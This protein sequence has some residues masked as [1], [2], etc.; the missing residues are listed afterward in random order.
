M[1]ARAPIIFSLLML[2]FFVS[3]SAGFAD[4]SGVQEQL[5][6]IQLKLIREKLKILQ[7]NILEAGKQQIQE[8]EA[9]KQRALPTALTKIEPNGEELA[10][11]LK[12]QVKT[13]Q[14]V[15]ATLRPRA[16]EEETARIEKRIGQIKEGL[17]T[18]AGLKLRS[19]QDEL[20]VLL[21]EYEA[22]QEQVRQSLSESI[23]YRQALVIGEQI[24]TIQAKVQ[25]LPREIVKPIA[26]AEAAPPPA[27]NPAVKAVEAVDRCL[28]RVTEAARRKGWT[29]LIT[30]DH[31]NCEQ[32]IDYETGQPH[33]YH[34]TN[35]VPFVVV[36]DE[37]RGA[38]LRGGGSFKAIAPTMLH[39]MGLE[40]P[41]EMEGETLLLG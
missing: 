38:R 28:A 7:E 10:R 31:G 27:V 21:A 33:T 9:A 15:I 8:R 26:R 25:T 23:T 3:T 22:L 19:L 20:N 2:F 17:K 24:R 35:P 16:I 34:T 36:G 18:A 6:S 29:V 14:G 39:L 32:M 4:L 12:E 37:F 41:E 11:T 5:R 40:K 30:A 1:F 13:L